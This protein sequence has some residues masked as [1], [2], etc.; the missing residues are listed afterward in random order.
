MQDTDEQA[1]AEFTNT[2]SREPTSRLRE[3][4]VLLFRY[5]LAENTR[6]LKLEKS[7]TSLQSLTDNALREW[8]NLTDV[9]FRWFMVQNGINYLQRE[10]GTPLT[11]DA[12]N[13]ELEYVIREQN[14]LIDAKSSLE[15]I[16]RNAATAPRTSQMMLDK[17]NA[18]QRVWV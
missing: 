11:L 12:A 3:R 9:V 1:I 7:Y 17:L 18:E 14:G 6:M 2:I 5:A 13:D 10:D 15:E 4:L 16:Y 8:Q